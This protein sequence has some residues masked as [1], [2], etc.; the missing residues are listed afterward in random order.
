MKPALVDQDWMETDLWR[1]AEAISGVTVA[2][3]DSGIE[4]N[5]FGAKTSGYALLYAREG[6]LLFQGGITDGRGHAGE[7]AGRA[8][9]IALIEGEPRAL[10]RTQTFGCPLFATNAARPDHS[11][12]PR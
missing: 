7:S 11:E 9:I 5:R 12:C 4:A 10:N 8:A 2:R 3:D 6:K 1:S